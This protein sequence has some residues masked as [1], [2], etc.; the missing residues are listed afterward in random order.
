MAFARIFR[1]FFIVS[2]THPLFKAF[3]YGSFLHF[4]LK[5]AVGAIHR[6]AYCKKCMALSRSVW[7]KTG[8]QP[9]IFMF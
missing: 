4:E 8:F 7:E 2:H 3:M 6:C 5:E 9:Y 1:M